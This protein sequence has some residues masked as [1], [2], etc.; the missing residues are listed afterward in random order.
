MKAQL[1][2]ISVAAAQEIA[3]ASDKAS[4]ETVRIKY[5]GKKGALTAILRGM[6]ALT[7]E[8][9]P[10]IGAYANTVRAN[11]EALLEEKGVSLASEELKNA[12]VK[13][14]LDVTMP[15]KVKTVGKLHPITQVENR[16]KE[17]FVGLGFD[18]VEGP[19]VESAYNNFDAL[20]APADHP[21]RDFQDTFYINDTT[22]LRTQTSPVQI[23]A[24]KTM[25]PPI[26]II[27]P[28]RVYRCDEVD[29]THS[30]MFHQLE[31]LV[32]DKNI[33]LG[34]LKGLLE[35]WA[36]EMFGENTK[37]RFRPH[38]F[39]FTEPSA[40][41]DVSCFVCGGKGCRLCK[42]EGWIELLGA[43]LVHPNVLKAGGIDPE[44]YSGLA[45][46]MGI[47][48]VVM[49]SYGID[50]MRHLYENDIR[51]LGQF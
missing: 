14:K 4:L 25:T 9:R 42:G 18:I 39:P 26:R 37:T 45:F 20:N 44:V 13:E 23:R 27:S 48:R 51:F 11:I 34:D 24:M 21:S 22:L 35:L 19:E 1:D 33:T 3:S 46:G 8:E 6:G 30:P 5:L 10:V 41:V 28:G 40:E 31:G 29:A 50:D 32:I 36:K 38:N 2:N 17:I 43:G 7:P 47:E 15:A 12:L 16:M 49:T